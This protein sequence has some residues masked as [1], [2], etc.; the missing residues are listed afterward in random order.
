MSNDKSRRASQ[1]KPGTGL[2]NG[3]EY[4][5]PFDELAVELCHGAA[6][7]LCILSPLL[8]HAAFDNAALAAAISAL[9]RR[10]RQSEVRILI[11]DARALVK[12][13]H[14][15]LRLARRMPTSLRIQK[16]AEHPDWKGQ[17]VV[18]RDRD[19]LLYKPG[20]ADHQGFFDY[21]SR[22]RARQELELF[23]ELWRH[24]APDIELRALSL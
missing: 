18:I 1:E 21:A 24:S 10:S 15:L 11:S 22:V 9:A 20:D 6:R 23:E 8:D 5:H 13:G 17:T 12:R 4:P 19:G 14:R 2:L 3:V 16:L 7:S